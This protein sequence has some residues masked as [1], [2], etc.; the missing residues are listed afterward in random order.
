MSLRS[1]GSRASTAVSAAL[2]Q[3]CQGRWGSSELSPRQRDEFVDAVRL[4][5]IAP[6]AHV[7]TRGVAPELSERLKPDR[8]RAFATNF[9][10]GA[11][12]AEIDRLLAG[13]VWV[14]FKGPVLSMSAH[15][16]PGLRSFTD[17]DVL[18]D[19]GQLRTVCELLAA[20]GWKLIDYDDMLA[21]RPAPGEMHWASPSG[22]LVDLHWA[23]INRE[24]RRERFRIPTGELLQRQQNVSVGFAKVPTLDAPDALIHVC[25]HASLDGAN[26]LLQLVDADG[27]ARQVQDWPAL[28]ERAKR[29]RAGV[30]VWLVL[31]RARAV[32]GTPL[33]DDLCAMLGVPWGMRVL[34]DVVDRLAPV[35]RARSEHGLAR[36]VARA[37]HPTLDATLSMLLRNS[38]QGIRDRIRPPV[39][40]SGRVAAEPAT[41]SAFFSEV[42]ERHAQA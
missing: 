6:L 15:P 16:A 17:I 38:L 40:R 28:A 30:Q 39:A 31:S 37:A 7:V 18:V 2:T 19:P 22:L 23:M 29:W 26:R 35:A 11:L 5:R 13:I 14:T 9:A 25:I 21:A 24:A 33:P 34:F 41:V 3:V 36:L 32:L 1:G 27:L 10:A 42:E 12:L 20:A 8:D 4:H